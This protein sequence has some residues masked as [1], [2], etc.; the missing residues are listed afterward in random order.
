MNLHTYKINYP[1][2][3]KS[4][5]SKTQ[6]QLHVAKMR[7]HS[8]KIDAKKS[9]KCGNIDLSF[10]YLWVVEKYNFLRSTL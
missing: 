2:T 4:F 3:R 10:L 5:L 8:Q 9:L 6:L 7:P 1:V